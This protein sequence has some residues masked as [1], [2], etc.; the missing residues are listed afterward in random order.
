MR[1]II[2]KEYTTSNSSNRDYH[3]IYILIFNYYYLYLYEEICYGQTRLTR[4]SM[5]FSYTKKPT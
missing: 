3:C 5:A 4:L 2:N 1:N